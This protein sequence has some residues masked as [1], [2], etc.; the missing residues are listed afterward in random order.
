MESHSHAFLPDDAK[1]S[2][3]RASHLFI[4]LTCQVDTVL[5][6]GAEK[7]DFEALDL[8]G[9]ILDHRDLGDLLVE[10]RTVA[11]VLG[12]VSIVQS[13]DG[14]FLCGQKHMDFE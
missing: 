12:P 6:P 10:L 4:A 11:D 1:S 5:L 2:A 3:P 7:I 9:Q 14:F 8:S 13:A